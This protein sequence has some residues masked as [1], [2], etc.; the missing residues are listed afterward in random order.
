MSRL[1]LKL[2]IPITSIPFLFACATT[3]P[4]GPAAQ[5]EDFQPATPLKEPDIKVYGV[6][7]EIEQNEQSR[8]K[9]IEE[10]RRAAPSVEPRIARNLVKLF[11]LEIAAQRSHNKENLI[12]DFIDYATTY[13]DAAVAARAY[14]L[15]QETYSASYA[16]TTARLWYDLD[17]SSTDAQE[18]YIKELIL[19]SQ[20]SE[21]FQ[22]MEL[23]HIQNKRTDFRLMA[24]FAQPN[25]EIEARQ[26][27]VLYQQYIREYPELRDNLTY[28][29]HLAYYQLGKFLFYQTQL[30][31]S[32]RVF[33]IV[34][35]AS[36]VEEEIAA[37][38]TVFKARLYYLLDK[39]SSNAFYNQ[40]MKNYPDDIQIPIF[41]ALLLLNRENEK[42]AQEVLSQLFNQVTSE[43][44]QQKIFLLAYL[45]QQ[46]GLAEL[47]D[48]T[49][50]YYQPQ[51]SYEDNAAM[52]LGLL[53]MT[54][55]AY[56]LAEEF[57]QLIGTDS[58]LWDSVQL[59]RL[60][61]FI[62]SQSFLVVDNLLE[63]IF[64]QDE[65]SYFTLVRGYALDLAQAGLRGPA[66]A[67]LDEAER[68]R[69][70]QQDLKLTKAYVYYELNELP[71][72]I[73]QFEQ[74][75]TDND[76]EPT[77]LNGFGYCLS[78]KNIQLER[79]K[80]MIEEAVAKDPTNSAYVDSLGWVNYRL[81]NLNRAYELLEWAYRNNQDGE[82]AA[83]LGEVLWQLGKKERAR[84]VWLA[85]YERDPHSPTLLK[86]MARFNV[87]WW[88]LAPHTPLIYPD[89]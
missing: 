28:G 36:V 84:V 7:L 47:E 45:A 79:A 2:L 5:I 26:L 39:V 31:Q 67:V 29:M 63:E 20:Y 66:I 83:H 76:A 14:E 89:I 13:Q 9:L 49:L 58:S 42:R 51:V 62:P 68:R 64:L 50:N 6:D 8:E 12:D 75:M 78:D 71:N 70:Y 72:M 60:K 25:N 23:R 61:N 46:L 40:A 15:A 33:N 56:S 74:L 86:T 4:P 34:L 11:E 80:E 16:L 69:P 38:A 10:E 1:H 82:I 30:E 24:I 43:G 73:A 32:L 17:T 81:S 77:L 55:G 53:A 27:V 57:F 54:K 59:L 3:P 85:Q 44:D 88:E 87:N 37:K 52:R 65:D 22:L 35:S 41:Y 48:Q 19:Q 18:S 21:A